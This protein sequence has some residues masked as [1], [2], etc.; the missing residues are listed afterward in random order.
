MS[1]A[2]TYSM[3]ES[4]KPGKGF[5]LPLPFFKYFQHCF[6]FAAVQNYQI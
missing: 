2:G 5:S 1:E 3:K 4:G 6:A